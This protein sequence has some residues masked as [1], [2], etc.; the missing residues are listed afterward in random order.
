MNAR[1]RNA[2][3]RDMYKIELKNRKVS[4]LEKNPNN[5]RVIK[6]ANYK[7]LKKSIEMDGEFMVARPV[8]V[9]MHPDRLNQVIGGNQRLQVV[10]DLGWAEVPVAE[11]YNATEEEEQRL[12]FKD[13][14]HAGE[15]DWA[16]LAAGFDLDFLKDVGFDEKDLNKILSKQD[17]SKDDE[18]D[19]N[20]VAED[21]TEPVCKR[22]EIWQLGKHRLMCGDS[23]KKEDVEMLMDGKKADICFTS[24]PYNLGIS[25]KLSGNTKIGEKG[26]AYEE[27]DDG[28]D[29]GDWYSLMTRF[30]ENA[31]DVCS[32]VFVNVQTLAGNRT[33]LPRYWN[34]FSE[35]YCDVLIWDKEHGTPA[36]ASRVMNSRFEFIF[37][38][39]RDNPN[40]AIR[41]SP[42]WRGIVDNVYTA[43]PQRNNEFAGIH[44]ATFPIHF[45]EFVVR[46]FTKDESSI[47]DAFLGTGTT[48]IACE[49][50]GRICYG[51]EIDPKYCD[52][53]IK[54]WEEKTGKKASKKTV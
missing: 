41:T 32:Y 46:T 38:F 54:R 4:E 45:P 16:A 42:E 31:L 3:R 40:R 9:S 18:F 37:I 13:N 27:Y 51:M 14:L 7:K 24:P 10:K 29:E 39:T 12:A 20:K 44:G 28:K 48:L 52:V 34:V 25:S 17:H 15:H 26:N 35:E 22:G 21:I 43:P 5:P 53:I 47:Y 49:N 19:A 8:V 36:A 50:L 33:A 11:V 2:E 6:D 1:L 30:T 23:T